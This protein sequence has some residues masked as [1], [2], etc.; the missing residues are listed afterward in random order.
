MKSTASM[1]E[2]HN[3]EQRGRGFV[4]F[5]KE[6]G[7]F[8]S[9]AIGSGKKVI[10][11]G[12]R[13]GSLT[14]YIAQGNEVWAADI[15]Q[16]ALVYL[17]EKLPSVEIVH[18]DLNKDEWDIPRNYFDAVVFAETLEH[19]YYPERVLERISGLLKTG[20]ILVGSVPNAFSLKNRFRMLFGKK[21]HSSLGDPTHVN[22]FSYRELSGLLSKYF[23]Q[24]RIY[25]LIQPKYRWLSKL[26]PNLF[27]FTLLFWAKK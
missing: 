15:D 8:I 1:Y 19:L 3:L 27:S 2:K 16:A 20:G 21:E 14:K 17:K 10:D 7:A 24:V 12:S 26:S 22:H 6:R 25:P 18:L 13:D 4:L 5:E 23:K 9:T 11:L